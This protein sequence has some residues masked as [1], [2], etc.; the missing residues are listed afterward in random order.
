[1]TKRSKADLEAALGRAQAALLKL[2]ANHLHVEIEGEDPDDYCLTCAT[3]S[4]GLG[5]IEPKPIPG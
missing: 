3:V 2:G 5:E 4:E 1:V